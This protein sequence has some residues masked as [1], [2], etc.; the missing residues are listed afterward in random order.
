M[1]HN[2]P[3]E[4]IFSAHMIEAL[5]H[6]VFLGSVLVV[7]ALLAS[8]GYFKQLHDQIRDEL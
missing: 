4:E 6:I 5:S 2:V 7:G 3:V 8:M 1:K